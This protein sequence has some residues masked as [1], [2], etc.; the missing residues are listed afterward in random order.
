MS[1]EGHPALCIMSAEVALNSVADQ[2]NHQNAIK[3]CY[4]TAFLPEIFKKCVN[5]LLA[6]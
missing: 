5:L 1:T 2:S 6:M 4:L 3:I